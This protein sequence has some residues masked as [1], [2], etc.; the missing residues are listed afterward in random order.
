MTELRE[1]PDNV[2]RALAGVWCSDENSPKYY[3]LEAPKS[4]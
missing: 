3:Q 4:I 1:E 2:D